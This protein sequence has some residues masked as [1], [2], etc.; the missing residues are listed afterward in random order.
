MKAGF[1]SL[2]C[3]KNLVDTEVMLGI[4]REHGIELTAEPAEA[5]I[6]IVNTCAF[7]QSAKEESITTVLGMA[8][9]KETGRC[10]SLIVAGCLG[11]RYGQQLLDEIPE[12]N[13]IIGTGAWSRIMEVVEE[14]LK[15]RRLVI[16]GE[17]DTIYDA[18]TPRLRTTP[19][20]TAYVKIAEG[21]DHRCAFCA[22]PLIRGGFR[23]RAMEDIV[24]E[25]R[26]LAE[27]GVRELVLIAQDS[28]NYGLDLYRK[29]MLASLLREL[30]K[31]EKISWI[32]VLYSYP[33]YF[34]DELIEVFATEPK[35][36]KYVDLPLQH[37]HDAVL[38]S[39]NRPDTRAGIERLIQ[40][41]RERIPGVTIRSTFIV[42]FPG[43]T[44]THYQALRDFV[45]AQRFDKLGIFT[46]SEEEDTPAS[47]MRQKV[48]EEVMQ[49][50][51]HDLMSL[52]SKISEEINIS[53]ENKEIDVLIEG[54]DSEQQ[55][56]AV[57]RS[58]REAPEVDGQIYIEGDVGSCIGDIVRV[59]LL[60]GFTYDIVGEKVS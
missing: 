30:A 44:D 52:Q 9:Y 17:D 25:A 47:L 23:S 46:Y 45:E 29:P 27:S 59:R 11:Q 34:S 1:I 24:S 53:L 6:L 56:I 55:G 16:A 3:A 41:L 8:D 38:R 4:M 18:N 43:E 22:I 50:R 21:C 19:N 5:D 31:I 37:A 20:Y 10:R 12:A 48:S 15:G 60:Q 57:G 36:V 40:K 39:M 28:A 35:V 2:G 51:Y 33:K 58:Y 26:E 14:T 13:A 54:R 32:R 49:E 42:G 7:I